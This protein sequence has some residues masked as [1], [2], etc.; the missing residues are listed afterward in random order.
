MISEALPL[1]TSGL[2]ERRSLQVFIL[3]SD[4]ETATGS[5][6]HGMEESRATSAAESIEGIQSSEMVPML[7]H[8]PSVLGV[9]SWISLIEWTIAGDAPEE[10]RTFAVMSMDTRLVMHWIRGDRVRSFA[11]RFHPSDK[12]GWLPDS[13]SD[14]SLINWLIN[15]IKS[16][17]NLWNMNKLPKLTCPHLPSLKP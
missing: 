13:G 9:K 8:R 7:M 16:K 3:N 17:M 6:T 11:T 1:I 2:I 12:E 5:S 10:R 15:Y 4:T 14:E